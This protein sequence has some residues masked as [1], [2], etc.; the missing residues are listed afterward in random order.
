MLNLVKKQKVG[1]WVALGALVLAIVS[2]II[3][4]AN[5]AGKGY[6]HSMAIAE[7]ILFSV[8][9]IILLAAIIVLPQLNLKGITKK[10]VDILTGILKILAVVFL[11]IALLSFIQNRVEGLAYILFSDPNIIDTIQAPDTHNLQSAGSAI[12]GFIFYG[13]SM[14]VAIVSAFFVTGKKEEE[15]L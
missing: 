5:V 6:F 8:L 7:V 12:A 10:L 2:A 14:I 15:K 11:T 4:G 1:T 13:L 3:Y 9:A